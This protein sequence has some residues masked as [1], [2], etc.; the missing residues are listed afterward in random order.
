MPAAEEETTAP[1]SAPGA[2]DPFAEAEA[3]PTAPTPATSTGDVW[4]ETAG[5]TFGAPATEF[6][7]AVAIQ[8]PVTLPDGAAKP[9]FIFGDASRPVDLWFLDTAQ[10]R[11]H[12]YVGRGTGNLTVAEGTE[13]EGTATYANG[14]WSAIFVRDLRSTNSVSFAEGQYVPISFSVW[15]GLD[16][17]RGS[18]RALTQWFYVYLGTREQKSAVG[19]MVQAG[20]SLLLI[21]LLAVYWIRRRV[22]KVA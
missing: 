15:D 21:E 8:L 2:E 4:G 7:D 13:V 19:P 5:E 12:Q 6:S 22:G 10:K 11:V 1:A 18:R 3:A 20:L 9:Y 17:E 16:R 14:E